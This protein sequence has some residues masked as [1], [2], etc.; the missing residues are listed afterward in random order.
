MSAGRARAYTQTE[1]CAVAYDVRRRLEPQWAVDPVRLQFWQDKPLSYGQCAKSTNS[2][3]CEIQGA[4][5]VVKRHVGRLAFKGRLA[6]S[7]IDP[8]TWLQV[9]DTIIDLTPDQEGHTA[10]PVICHMPA[11]LE[12]IGLQYFTRYSERIIWE[13]GWT[14]MT[15]MPE[16]PQILQAWAARPDY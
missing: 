2:V 14:E 10:L 11:Q 1:L 7:E 13:N 12:V 5:N 15:R 8:H 9:D 6:L 4:A 3:L 16:T